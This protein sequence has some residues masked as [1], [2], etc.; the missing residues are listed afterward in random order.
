[1]RSIYLN[2]PAEKQPPIEMKQTIKA[3]IGGVFGFGSDTCITDVYVEQNEYFLGER[4]TV[5]IVCNNNKCGK[6]V[7]SFKLKV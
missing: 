2:R 4:A 1:M 6:D 3:E 5:R 7:K